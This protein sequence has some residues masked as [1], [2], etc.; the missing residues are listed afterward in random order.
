[1]R[2]TNSNARASTRVATEDAREDGDGDE[3]LETKETE[4]DVVVVGVFWDVDNAPPRAGEEEVMA[5]RIARA[6]RAFGTV[7]GGV[8]AYANAS[9]LDRAPELRKVVVV[10][11]V[12]CANEKDAADEAMGN[13][14]MAWASAG[15]R[16]VPRFTTARA[17]KRDDAS[18]EENAYALVVEKMWRARANEA[19]AALPRVEGERD[20]VKA[21]AR[22]RN[23]VLV[24]VTC[25]N[26]LRLA[27]DYACA[28]GVCVVILANISPT[29]VG[30]RGGVKTK[31]GRNEARSVGTVGMN[32]AYFEAIKLE[33]ERRELARLKLLQSADGA[34]VWDPN[35]K[36]AVS[37]EE[38]KELGKDA[39]AGDVV[40]V[41]RPDKGGIGRW[42][43]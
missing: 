12:E 34:L 33:G 26:D 17:R 15:A 20:A 7:D 11:V 2:R 13:A 28:Q 8:R 19:R 36:F 21:I 30:A 14:A 38:A 31:R 4:D 29:A 23:R 10:E 6:A 41:W 27:M 5:R 16:D 39:V 22:G 42:Y 32:N 37:E 43:A 24:L 9:T 18:V 40:G 35:R 25:D 3:S 1:M